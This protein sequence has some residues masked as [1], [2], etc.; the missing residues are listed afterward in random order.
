MAPPHALRGHFEPF[1]RSRF[2]DRSQQFP[3][4]WGYPPYGGDDYPPEYTAPSESGPVPSAAYPPFE[5]FSERSRP[6]V[7][8]QPGCR[9]DVQKVPSERGGETT[10][11]VTRCY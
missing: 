7:F 2:K 3:P 10:V 4:G 8:Y 5:N 11:N 6:P 1:A 9:T